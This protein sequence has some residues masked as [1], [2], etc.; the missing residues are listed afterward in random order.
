MLFY[1]SEEWRVRAEQ[2]RSFAKQTRHE[3]YRVMALRIAEDYE[4]LAGQADSEPAVHRKSPD[5]SQGRT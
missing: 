2:M 5:R 4:R 3:N 1:H